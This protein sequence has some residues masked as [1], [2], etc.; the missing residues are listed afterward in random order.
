MKD[1][2]IIAVSTTEAPSAI[3]P[4]S[5]A[6]RC[7]DFLFLSGQVALDPKTLVLVGDSV[8]TQ[9]EQV[10]KNLTAVL[11][12]QGLTLQSVVKTTVFLKNMGDFVKFNGVY[13]KH[14][15]AP[16][17]ARATIEVARLPKDALVEIEAVATF[18]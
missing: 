9:T 14:L 13:E 1:P 8:E 3:G 11:K 10:M 5:Q 15:K 7:G 4:Y 6:I 17:P 18:L 2:K 12:S 16:F